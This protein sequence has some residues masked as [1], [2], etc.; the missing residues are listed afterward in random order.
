MIGVD[1]V[2]IDDQQL[3]V[4]ERELSGHS[5]ATA[6]ARW[7]YERARRIRVVL[8]VALAVLFLGV[9]GWGM[10]RLGGGG[11]N[12]DKNAN[13]AHPT[14][15]SKL[16]QID[17]VGSPQAELK[18]VAILPSGSDC[19]SDIVT[20]LTKTAEDR[21]EKVRVEFKNMESFSNEELTETVGSVCAA[22]MVNNKSEFEVTFENKPRHVS[23]VGTVP[24]H[25]TLGDLGLVITEQYKKL[26]GDPGEPIVEVPKGQEPT[27]EIHDGHGPQTQ[28]ADEE[29][30]TRK[31]APEELLL[32][33]FGTRNNKR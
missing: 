24:T 21:P 26:Y 9:F 3:E 6:E 10:Y 2:G 29:T 25:Y 20:F 17:P 30:K 7:A 28:P 1:P 33:S 4:V 22:V 27:C 5:F 31:L 15:P 11:G 19:H 12:A 23:L 32:P 18:I 13:G 16:V 8:K 14:D